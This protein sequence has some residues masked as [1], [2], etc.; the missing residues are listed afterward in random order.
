MAK[1]KVTHFQRKLEINSVTIKLK[2][3]S[4]AYS[5]VALGTSYDGNRGERLKNNQQIASDCRSCSYTEW[6]Y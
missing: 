5:A 3:N 4:H 6:N 1:I 2:S